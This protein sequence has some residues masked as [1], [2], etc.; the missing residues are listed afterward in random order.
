MSR[1]RYP[2]LAVATVLVSLASLAAGFAP[3]AQGSP[4][5]ASAVS[6]YAYI[7]A[8]RQGSAVYV[9]ALVK[10]NSSTGV[11][12]SPNRTVYLQRDVGNGWQSMLSR[13]TNSQGTFTVGFISVAN[14]HYRF[15][16]IPSASALGT[17]SGLAQT[18]SPPV[19]YASCAA[20]R[21]VYP[22]GVGKSGAHDVIASGGSQVL[23]FIVSTAVYAAQS[24][25]RDAD[26]DGVA[27]E[28]H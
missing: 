14:Y 5:A 23:N 28:K 25:A 8:S 3:S 17:T 11:V 26:H 7:S 22:H 4:P 16:V 19:R 12:R 27:C 20:L 2:R 21:G 13:V 1:A 18:T 9:N 6:S 10:Q 15:V 24:T